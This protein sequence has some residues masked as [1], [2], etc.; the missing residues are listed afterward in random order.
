MLEN[1][2]VEAK[3]KAKISNL[4]GNDEDKDANVADRVGTTLAGAG[5]GISRGY[6]VSR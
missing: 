3:A 2:K 1:K 6:A 5:S 4:T